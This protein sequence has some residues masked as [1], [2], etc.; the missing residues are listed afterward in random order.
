MNGFLYG[1]ALQW[2]MDIRSKSLLIT[3]YVVP[4]IFFLLMGGIFT[5]VMP[6]MEETLIQT[7]LV[8]GV[9]MAAFIGYPTSLSETYGGE[10]KKVYQASRVPLSLGLWAMLLSAFTHLLI[11]SLL[12]LLLAPLLFDA[13]LPENLPAFF[14]AL[15]VFILAC[16]SVGSVL[17]LGVNSQARLNMTAQLLFLPSIMLS[18][19]MFPAELLPGV[20]QTAGKIFPAAWGY[21]LMQNQGL[22]FSNLWPLLLISALSVP[23]CVLLMKKSAGDR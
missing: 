22:A 11:M 6:Q 12:I 18:G 13:A 7:M 19:I 16:L 5:S 23:A 3:C 1:A 4:L 17:G 20:L 15:T 14:T 9:S 10:I 8:M 2:K 21:R